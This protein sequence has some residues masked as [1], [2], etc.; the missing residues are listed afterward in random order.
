[1]KVIRVYVRD[2]K[3]EKKK[4]LL[5]LG[6]P[7]NYELAVIEVTSWGDVVCPF[8]VMNVLKW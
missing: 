8:L 4:Q 7:E 1:M 2:L 3:D 5:D 6:I